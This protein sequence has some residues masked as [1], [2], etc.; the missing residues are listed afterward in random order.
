MISEK[1]IK[2]SIKKPRGRI[3]KG[4]SWDSEKGEWKDNES[5]NNNQIDQNEIIDKDSI[6]IKTNSLE[7]KKDPFNSDDDPLK[8]NKIIIK[9][10]ETLKQREFANN[11][12]IRV[13]AYGKAIKV[14]KDNFSTIPIKDGK[15]LKEFKGIGDKIAKKVDEIIENGVLKS[16]EEARNDQKVKAINLFSDIHG[17]GPENAQ[18]LVNLNI[19]TIEELN[20]RKDEI[21]ENG[22]PLLNRNQQLGL[23]YYKPLLSRIPRSEMKLHEELFNSI[24]VS[25]NKKYP[26]TSLQI[27]GSF[28][29]ELP[30]SGDIDVLITNS[31]NKDIVFN[32]FIKNLEDIN[33]I[34]DVLGHGKKKFFG[35]SQLN[36]ESLPRRLDILYTSPNEFPFAQLYFTGSGSFNTIF[37]EYVSSLGFRLNEYKLQNYNPKEMPKLSPVDHIFRTEK[38]IFDFFNIPYIEPKDRDSNIL[39]QELKKIKNN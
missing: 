1:K 4:K 34:I 2:I 20:K 25:I 11:D 32:T 26:G 37:R 24:L 38:D 14:I 27:V 23:K 16:A 36:K 12:K 33:Y 3:P 31:N 10:L 28:R 30:D 17:I 18:R 22:K 8:M 21:Q 15:Q 39:N 19:S 13:I 9:E 5:I 29:R 6:P 7:D 35:V